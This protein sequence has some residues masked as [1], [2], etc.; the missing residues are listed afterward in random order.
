MAQA[1]ARREDW[2]DRFFI[3]GFV[4]GPDFAVIPKDD[5]VSA[6]LPCERSVYTPDPISSLAKVGH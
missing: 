4:V 2:R 6:L 3:V 5:Q 1:K